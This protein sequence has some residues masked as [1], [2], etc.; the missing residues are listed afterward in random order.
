MGL[1]RASWKGC[2]FVPKY[3]LGEHPMVSLVRAL[4]LS[5]SQVHHDRPGQD[6]VEEK[7]ALSEFRSLCELWNACGARGL[8]MHILGR[9]PM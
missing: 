3:E 1:V 2:F 9:S 6:K 8:G 7:R 4:E 5:R